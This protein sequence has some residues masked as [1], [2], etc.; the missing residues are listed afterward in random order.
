MSGVPWWIITGSGD[1]LALL[2]QSLTAAH[3]RWLPKTHS[4]PNWTMSVFSS[5]VTSL[6]LIY[7]SVTSSVSDVRWLTLHRWTLNH[8]FNL[9]DFSS[10]SVTTDLQ[11]SY[12]SFYTSVQT[13]CRTLPWTVCLL[14][15]LFVATG[16]CLPNWC[17]SVDCSMSIVM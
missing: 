14:L 1:L 8:D 7:K 15:H 16:M 17:L 5:I 6:I 11:I 10:H 13:E 12:V 2:L 9:T 3:N 4:I